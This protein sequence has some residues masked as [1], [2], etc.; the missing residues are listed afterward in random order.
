MKAFF[1]QAV[2]SP[3][4]GG[5]MLT[6]Y[7]VPVFEGRLV[8]FDVTA[9]EARGRWLPWDVLE[10]GEN[11]Y[12]AASELADYWIETPPVSLE[13]VD[14]M[15]LNPPGSP[16][17]LALIFRCALDAKPVGQG[18]RTAYVFDAG[19]FDAI[20]NFDPVDL[21]RWVRRTSAPD[22]LVDENPTAPG[23]GLIF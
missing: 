5:T 9:K 4:E 8:C 1:G 18:E 23:E 21:E 7:L 13:L 12:E 20:G 14:V 3:I 6:V 19:D 17:E 16:W 2:G 11:P 15:S 10:V 22:A